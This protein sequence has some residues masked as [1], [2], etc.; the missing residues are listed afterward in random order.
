VLFDGWMIEK[1]SR[2]K[3]LLPLLLEPAASQSILLLVLLLLLLALLQVLLLLVPKTSEF[4]G[5]N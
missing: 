2:P 4:A 1:L 5:T 3:V